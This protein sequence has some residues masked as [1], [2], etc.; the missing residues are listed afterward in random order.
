MNVANLQCMAPLAHLSL[1]SVC[2]STHPMCIN[3]MGGAEGGGGGGLGGG[4]DGEGGGSGGMGGC[5]GGGGASGGMGG[6]GNG[7]GEGGGGSGGCGVLIPPPQKQQYAVA[8]KSSSSYSPHHGPITPGVANAPNQCS[9]PE[10]W[11]PPRSKTS[12]PYWG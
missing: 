5:D 9:Y 10:H 2:G 12:Q 1:Q 7:G 8:V 3:G 6:G 4:G 11:R